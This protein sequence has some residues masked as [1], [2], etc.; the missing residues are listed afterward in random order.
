MPPIGRLV[1]P[2]NTLRCRLLVC[3]R[4]NGDAACGRRIVMLYNH[5]G[6][7]VDVIIQL[8]AVGGKIDFVVVH[9]VFLIQLGFDE[10]DLRGLQPGVFQ[11]DGFR[12][13]YADLGGLALLWSAAAACGKKQ[14]HN[15]RRSHHVF[16]HGV[17][18]LFFL[19]SLV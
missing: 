11:C 4:S 6:D 19:M 2:L 16:F 14:G 10:A 3:L 1:L 7:G 17:F 13:I 18:L 9:V 15:R 12:R 5:A 8:G